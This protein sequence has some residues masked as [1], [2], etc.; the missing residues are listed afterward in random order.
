MIYVLTYP[1]RLIDRIRYQLTG[2]L[3]MISGDEVRYGGGMA[4][5]ITHGTNSCRAIPMEII[6]EVVFQGGYN[7]ALAKV[8]KESI[9]NMKDFA[10]PPNGED[11]PYAT[12]DVEP[13]AAESN[14][15]YQ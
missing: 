6:M 14:L 10:V 13:M 7:E 8:R 5:V 12:D 11:I 2:S 9:D 1:Q 4:E 3:P 15:T